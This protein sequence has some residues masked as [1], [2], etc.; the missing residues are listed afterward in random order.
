MILLEAFQQIF[1]F[2]RPRIYRKIFLLPWV[3]KFKKQKILWSAKSNRL[4]LNDN[5]V[6]FLN[7][8]K[9]QYANNYFN[10]GIFWFS[11]RRFV[12]SF[13]SFSNHTKELSV[14]SLKVEPIDF[15]L[16][17]QPHPPRQCRVVKDLR[18]THALSIARVRARGETLWAWAL[19]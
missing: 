19:C 17:V 8:R 15:S 12:L 3:F 4:I 7:W 16:A 11:A 5:L 2:L 9:Q 18:G 1:K 6:K 13:F 10:Y 14:K